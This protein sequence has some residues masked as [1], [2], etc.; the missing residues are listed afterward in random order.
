MTFIE[1]V[2]QIRRRFPESVVQGD[3][4][5]TVAKTPDGGVLLATIDHPEGW[6]NDVTL[7]LGAANSK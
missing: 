5:S 6:H 4:R 7:R 1:A 2:R 3:D